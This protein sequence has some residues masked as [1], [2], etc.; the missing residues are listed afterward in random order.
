MRPP[1]VDTTTVSPA[2][3][4]SKV[5]ISQISVPSPT[6]SSLQ[7]I[8]FLMEHTITYQLI[9]PKISSEFKTT[10]WISAFPNA[11]PRISSCVNHTRL[12]LCLL[13]PILTFS[14]QICDSS[15]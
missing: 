1:R 10:R 11:K 5:T 13:H 8:D 3:S 15:F 4:N 12:D 6:S 14:S 2:A 9:N 7:F